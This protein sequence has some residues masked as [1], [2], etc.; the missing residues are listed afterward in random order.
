MKQFKEIDE[1]YLDVVQDN[2]IAYYAIGDDLNIDEVKNALSRELPYYMIPS[3]F[4]EVDEIPLNPNGK[5]DKFAL[6]DIVRKDRNLDIEINDDVL[7]AVV[8][9]FK[10][11]LR[12]DSVMMDDDFVAMGGNSLSA[13][14]LQIVL[15][16]KLGVNLY[17]N[18]IIELKTPLAIANHIKSDSGIYSPVIS[19]YSFD[20]ICPLSEAQLNVYLDEMVN[21]VGTAYNNPY[22]LEF[23][24]NYSIDEIRNAIDILL[25]AYPVLSARIIN[26]K[27]LLSLSFDV[28]P[29][30]MEGSKDDIGS[31][32][33]PFELDKSLS[34]FLMI[35]NDGSISLCLDFHHLI[36]DRSSINIALNSLNSIL[37]GDK[38][39][40]SDDG[41]L[42]QISFEENISTDY[43]E[44]AGDFFASMLEDRDEAYG[45]LPSVICSDDDFE[46]NSSFNIDNANLSSNEIDDLEYNS[47]FNIDNANLSSNEIDDYEYNSCFNIDNAKLSS[48]LQDNSITNNQFF[49]SVSLIHYQDLQEIQRPYLTLLRMAED[50]LTSLS[51]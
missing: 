26:E 18:E 21:D 16:E 49:A 1:V 13:M 36:F 20:D 33:R 15:N 41:V 34:R 37:K 8:D 7:A 3:M 45:L 50:I 27:E 10:D 35:E 47:C 22:I 51:L 31:F 24:G 38:I 17:S 39:D 23:N 11:V 5:I 44:N 9:A 40:S 14:K 25:E 32:I 4:I 12:S 48:F 19:N 28:K 30:I 29:E 46:Y 2:L 6:R 42:R 43:M